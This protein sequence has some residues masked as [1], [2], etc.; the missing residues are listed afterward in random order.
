MNDEQFT[1]KQVYV[2]VFAIVVGIAF[3]ETSKGAVWEW[4][5]WKEFLPKVIVYGV[6]VEFVVVCLSNYLSKRGH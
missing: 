2:L 3:I 1:A 4:I 5:F 6:I